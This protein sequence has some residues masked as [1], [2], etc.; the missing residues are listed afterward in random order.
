MKKHVPRLAVA[1]VI[2]ARLSVL[3][4]SNIPPTARLLLEAE[5]LPLVVGLIRRRITAPS[6]GRAVARALAVPATPEG[7]KGEPRSP[8]ASSLGRTPSARPDVAGPA[9]AS[10]NVVT[11]DTPNGADNLPTGGSL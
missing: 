8:L 10:Q 1:D 9:T 2:D 3:G 7:S 5:L 4:A 11:G 6:V